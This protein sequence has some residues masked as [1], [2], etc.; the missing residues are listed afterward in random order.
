MK[1]YIVNSRKEKFLTTRERKK[2]NKNLMIL[3]HEAREEFE[4]FQLILFCAQFSMRSYSSKELPVYVSIQVFPNK[5]TYLNGSWHYWLH[6]KKILEKGGWKKSEK[7]FKCFTKKKRKLLKRITHVQ[8]RVNRD[9]P[10]SFILFFC[11]S[12]L[13]TCRLVLHLKLKYAL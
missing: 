4:A 9:I 13:R 8:E 10:I 6:K 11:S 7:A 2:E 1:W 12:T 5:F 3:G